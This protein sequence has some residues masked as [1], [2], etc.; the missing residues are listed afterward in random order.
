MSESIQT[1]VE[2]RLSIIRETELLHSF[3][4]VNVGDEDEFNEEDQVEVEGSN[5]N[6]QK[7]TEGKL[8]NICGFCYITEL[9]ILL[10]FHSV[11][12]YLFLGKTDTRI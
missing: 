9:L 12:H 8:L 4:R 7:K 2:K 6:Q 3:V 5:H 11:L 1:S 10:I